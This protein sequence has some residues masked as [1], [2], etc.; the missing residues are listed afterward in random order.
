MNYNFIGVK[1]NIYGKA[2]FHLS[3]FIPPATEDWNHDC[4]CIL[5]QM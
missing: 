4:S 5:L 3:D 2:F 1:N